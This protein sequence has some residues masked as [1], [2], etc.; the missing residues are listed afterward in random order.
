MEITINKAD[1]ALQLAEE[2]KIVLDKARDVAEHGITHFSF[3]SPRKRLFN[4]WELVE[5]VEHVSK[6]T[7]QHAYNSGGLA[8]FKIKVV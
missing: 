7:V 8:I 5:M 2:T 1:K 4:I 6:N 3:P